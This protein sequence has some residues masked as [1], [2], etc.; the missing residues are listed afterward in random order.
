MW[1][2]SSHR[3]DIP[4]PENQKK[5]KFKKF[6]IQFFFILI[7]K[8][9]RKYIIFLL[10]KRTKILFEIFDLEVLVFRRKSFGSFC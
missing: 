8:N 5:S 1:K 3:K 9:M 7:R 2:K 10:E 4:F 6:T